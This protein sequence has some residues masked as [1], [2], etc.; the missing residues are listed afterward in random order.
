MLLPGNAL[1]LLKI[2]IATSL[3]F[4]WVVRYSNIVTEFK[5]YSLPDWFRDLMGIV[6]LCFAVLL[7]QTSPELIVIG[8]GGLV[9]LMMAAFL[10]HIKFKHTIIQMVPSLSLFLSS[11]YISFSYL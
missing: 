8:S 5:E 10:V 9:V 1:L 2:V 7:F 4:V 11:L 6:K 3:F